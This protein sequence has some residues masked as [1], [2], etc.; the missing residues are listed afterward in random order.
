M[1]ALSS[2]RLTLRK[3]GR[4]SDW[5]FVKARTASATGVVW[6]SVDGELYKRTGRD[7]LREEAEFQRRAIDLGYP[8]PEIISSGSEDGTYYVIE[9]SLG[10]ATLHDQALADARRD[11]HVST[12][13]ITTAAKISAQL[14]Q[15]QA[16]IPQTISAW[17]DKAAFATNVFDENP[18]FD[19]PRTRKLVER[20]VDRMDALPGCLGH[21]DYGLP[22][23]LASGVIDWQHHGPVPLGYDVYPA[24]DIVAFKGGGKGYCL[25][26][27][28]RAEYVAALDEVSISLAGR[29]LSEHLGEFLLV[30]CFFFLALMRPTDPARHDKH[31][32]WQY[33][34][35]LFTMG[36]GQY[37]ST[38]T[39]DTGTFP[40]LE[41]FAA[42]Y[43]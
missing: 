9:R 29:R 43:R 38:G 15:A 26:A 18:D 10:D 40:T 33:R 31:I 22:N 23:I 12:E 39:I 13:V 14:L 37:E 2:N 28:Q 30:K 21:L 6:R 34:R 20:A 25:G 41:R 32:K 42:G 27:E 8:V 5:E 17:F 36:L 3:D 7:E 16:R 11:G 24:L 35:A 4:M 19:T 1:P